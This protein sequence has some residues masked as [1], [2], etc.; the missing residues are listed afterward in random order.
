MLR[1]MKRGTHVAFVDH[2]LAVHR[3]SNP[4]SIF[5]RSRALGHYMYVF[6]IK[7]ALQFLDES[8]QL[9]PYRELEA[10][11]CIFSRAQKLYALHSERWHE[12]LATVRCHASTVEPLLRRQPPWYRVAYRVAGFRSAETL[13]I[14][15]NRMRISLNRMRRF[16]ASPLDT[17]R[18]A[19][20]KHNSQGSRR[21]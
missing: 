16:A 8:G 1:L 7:D 19:V 20:V 14:S 13:R 5:N 2:A 12:A 15:L 4:R 17:M 6:L 9:T 11:T 10:A 3:D 21:L 18:L